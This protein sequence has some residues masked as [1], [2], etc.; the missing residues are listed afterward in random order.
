[1]RAVEITQTGKM[2]IVEREIPQ[3]GVDEILLILNMWGFVALTLVLI[4]VKTLWSIRE[5][6]D[7]KYQL[8]SKKQVQAYHNLSKQGNGL[9]SS[10]TPIADSAHHVN[11]KGSMHIGTT[12][13]LVF[14]ETEEWPD[15]SLFPG[16]KYWLKKI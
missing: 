15:I 13:P 3:I 7:T 16:K 9:L 1:M 5:F 10:H 2:K 14:S 4:P 11:K 12:R 8:L 6:Q